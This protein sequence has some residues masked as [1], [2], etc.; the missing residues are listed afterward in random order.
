MSYQVKKSSGFTLIE[1]LLALAIM[2]TLAVLAAQSFNTAVNTVGSSEDAMDRLAEIDGA[3]VLMETD[4]RNAMAVQRFPTSTTGKPLPAMSVAP[5]EDYVLTLL[6]GGVA[7]PL[8]QRRTEEARVGY[9][10]IEETLWRD[11]WFDPTEH[12]ETEAR[13]RRILRGL[14]SFSVRV[15]PPKPV[16]ILDDQWRE[17]WPAVTGG[18]NVPNE[19]LPLAVKVKFELKDMGEVERIFI[20][21]PDKATIVQGPK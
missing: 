17:N 5:T 15:L 7:N 4:L 3:M 1:I 6:R 10:F 18:P 19:T 11:T 16:S 14:E 21:S 2:A 12:E 8:M 13:K 20:L 9:R